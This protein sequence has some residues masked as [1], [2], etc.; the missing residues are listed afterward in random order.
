MHLCYAFAPS[1]GRAMPSNLQSSNV[2]GVPLCQD[3]WVSQ[4]KGWLGGGMGGLVLAL[5]CWGPL[6][7]TPV[8][9]DGSTQTLIGGSGDCSANCLITGTSRA[10]ENL[11]HSF[12]RFNVPAA[13]TVTFDGT[14]MR[15][16]L[17]RVTGGQ[18]SE[19]RGRLAVTGT[20]NLFLLNPQGILFH[21]TATLQMQGS[22]VGS[23]ANRLQFA[24]G[25][26]FTTLTATPPLLT[27]ST[28]IGVSFGSNPGPIQVEGAS[29]PLSGPP[30]AI[31]SNRT[32]A[33]LGGDVT[34]RNSR[35]AAPDGSLLLHS[36]GADS[37]LALHSSPTGFELGMDQ[38]NLGGGLLSI[39][40]SLLTVRGRNGGGQIQLQGG[41]IQLD[42][43]TL[44]NDSS[45]F[46][47]L[48][49]RGIQIR[50]QDHLQLSNGTE[51]RTKTN[52]INRGGSI[53]LQADRIVLQG[54]TDPSTPAA[55]VIAAETAAAGPGGS[56]SLR[57]N[58]LD[59][60]EFSLVGTET[61]G[62]GAAG[63]VVLDAGTLRV[64]GA[65]VVSSSVGGS[66]GGG[67][68][69]RILVQATN[70]V[71]LEGLVPL[72]GLPAGLATETRGVSLPG[73][74]AAGSITVNVDS[75]DLSIEGGG[76]ISASTFGSGKAS[77][78]RIQAQNLSLAGSSGMIKSGIFSQVE[79]G[80][81]GSGGNIQVL[82][83]RIRLQDRGS[84]G[85][86]TFAAGDA[87]QIEIQALERLDILGNG[88]G[89]YAQVEPMA[90]GRG[91]SIQVQTP[92]LALDQ[93]ARVSATTGGLGAGGNINLDLG[94]LWLGGGAQVQAATLGYA[95]GGNVTVN[96]AESVWI[97]GVSG[98]DQAPSGLFSSTGTPQLTGGDQ[99]A[100]TIRV[101]TG[102]LELQPGA[103]IS[104]AS[105]NAGAGGLID[106]QILG[107][108]R[109]TGA[110]EGTTGVLVSSTGL[111][112]A[113]D[114]E[115][116]A[117][118]LVL[119]QRATLLAETTSNDGGNISLDLGDVLLMR[120]GAVISATAGQRSGEGDG[121]NITITAP[122]ILAVPREDS[123][124]I[125]N[126]FQGRGG[127][128]RLTTQ[129]VLGLVQRPAW[130]GN[131]TNDID[132]SSEAG[133]TGTVAIAQALNQDEL[134]VTPI[135]EAPQDASAWIGSVCDRS[136]HGAGRFV[137][138][139]RGGLPLSPQ[140]N[141]GL[142]AILEDPSQGTESLG[143]TEGTLPSRAE[144]AAVNPPQRWREAQGW[145]IT[146]S[147]QIQLVAE[148]AGEPGRL[149]RG[150][151]GADAVARPSAC[152][153]VRSETDR[154]SAR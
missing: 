17:T 31:A 112:R 66:S 100:G 27:V 37:A 108:A 26:E 150:S 107:M 104:A 109:F 4:S 36:A 140:T 38:D 98:L 22:F 127:N 69:G 5:G 95:P 32:L 88:T 124:I 81:S 21:P 53:D 134:T 50:A 1:Q 151:L 96:S 39:Q 79:R 87:G 20:A 137:M 6:Q 47:T 111:G 13:V 10:G 34:I 92:H 84:I 2:K 85:N 40:N 60:R 44:Q 67:N 24:D 148:G 143:Y 42:R 48:D 12:E 86:S 154:R 75:G 55:T 129:G 68:G 146:P 152:A 8:L 18:A 82:A 138:T 43:S 52:G 120:R 91:G 46:A 102:Q 14:G 116:A 141:Y 35:L 33:F 7:A 15:Q 9:P 57:A 63:D 149:I 78:I 76:Q 65:R 130:V 11:F 99:P 114:I 72:I 132:A 101:Q 122:F 135:P 123:D 147:G 115:V 103:R 90:T 131:G 77:S 3:L 51:L 126:A 89:L 142:W 64:V 62:L 25:T 128:I 106:L 119:D 80:G 74:L 93:A 41:Q 136:H 153:L 28:P 70:H 16:I 56:L 58:Q 59:I 23:T 30:P 144:P 117:G 133:A 45:P 71:H 73:R 94:Q 118:R 145:Q 97:G 105:F 83:E 113:G 29:L 54:R 49:S 19:I 125:A 110:G 61:T 121:G 139:G